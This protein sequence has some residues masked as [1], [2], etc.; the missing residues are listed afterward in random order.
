MGEVERQG[1]GTM[2]TVRVTTSNR[3]ATAFRAGLLAALVTLTVVLLSTMLTSLAEATATDHGASA[4]QTGT[5]STITVN[6]TVDELNSDGDCSLREAIQAAN[7][8]APVDACPAGSGADTVVV[9]A[10][11]YNLTIAGSGE[12]GNATGD[13]DVLGSLTLSGHSSGDTIIDGGG[14]D[15]V[16]HLQ[17]GSV[18]IQD[19][20]VRNGGGVTH[21]GGAFV[22]GGTLSLL[23]TKFIDNDA[24]E[25]VDGFG[26]GGLYIGEATVTV[27]ASTFNA[28]E[29]FE[30]GGIYNASG[31]L[32][33]TGTTFSGNGGP[34]TGFG[35]G[36]FNEGTVT[37]IDSVFSENTAGFGAGIS[38]FPP[39]TVTV[40]NCTFSGNTGV[41]GTGGIEN[42]LGELTVI[43]SSFT[44]NTSLFSGGAL[45]NPGV[46]MVRESVFTGNTADVG[47]GAIE[48]VG[49]LTVTGSIISGNSTHL[50]KGGAI[51]TYYGALT[52]IDSTISGNSAP[53]GGGIANETQGLTV[54]NSTI[55]GNSAGLG[56]GIYNSQ[57]HG[58]GMGT[59]NLSHVTI[60]YNSAITEGGGIY[61]TANA[62]IA[63]THL[64][65]V[66]NDGGNCIGEA[67]SS[68]QTPFPNLD[69][70]GTCPG[71]DTGPA[72]LGPLADNGGPTWTHLPASTDI[73][74]TGDNAGCAPADQRGVLRPQ[75]GDG[76]GQ[77]LCDL[78]AVERSV[79]I[80]QVP[81]ADVLLT[82]PVEGDICHDLTYLAAVMPISAT[83][84][85][86]YAWEASLQ[87][88][89]TRYGDITDTVTYLWF[90]P[91]VQT[92]TVTAANAFSTVSATITT[93]LHE[94]TGDIPIARLTAVNNSPALPLAPV[95]LTATVLCGTNVD[96]AW[97][98]G[99]GAEGAGATTT[100]SYA[101][102]G[103][104]TAVVTATNSAGSA[105]AETLVVI[106]EPVA[107]L[108]ATC[109]SPLEVGMATMCE[110]TVS[111]GTH[112][113]YTWDFGDGDMGF[114]PTV[115]HTYGSGGTY[116]VTVTAENAVSSATADAVVIVEQPTSVGLTAFGSMGTESALPLVLALALVVGILGLSRR[117]SWFSQGDQP[118]K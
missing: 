77:A 76:D 84:P 79:P 3:Q 94:I 64:V 110:A 86:E 51:R 16:L 10:G 69:S 1:E 102:A 44:G 107:G 89:I 21:G 19:L 41:Y 91:G 73:V 7:T 82:G 80:V 27:S 38:I 15:R 18:V 42:Y 33:V 54:R 99:D 31:T 32:T 70:D 72:V 68:W 22:A 95:A 43:G 106:Q 83:W 115:V 103:D 93:T 92:V 5:S 85:I 59:A 20:T 101:E 39:G 46:T 37:A 4:G 53:Q 67:G 113:S 45:F 52:L 65:V 63:S 26:G 105:T 55:S 35:G 98:F 104:Y 49:T 62:S 112:L 118:D 13:L 24:L 78:G 17:A 8:D 109:D 25:Y 28:N 61:N 9:P 23:N 48:N 100:H 29:A 96:Y 34:D 66:H 50:G 36:I 57:D 87:Q 40:R 90:T 81:L 75:D 2:N 71:F 12:D 58:G 117:R 111:A 88:P 74:D 6:T 114:G 47:A 116:T 108:A 30:G 56:G 14:Q 97:G 11:I 60:A